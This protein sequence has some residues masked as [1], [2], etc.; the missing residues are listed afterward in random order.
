MPRTFGSTCKVVTHPLCDLVTYLELVLISDHYISDRACHEEA[1]GQAYAETFV[2]HGF[3]RCSVAGSSRDVLS[4][5]FRESE[6]RHHTMANRKLA[7][8]HQEKPC[9]ESRTPVVIVLGS[10]VVADSLYA[11]SDQPTV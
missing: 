3:S 9:S 2:R 1:E 11:E 10:L 8:V 5:K 7:W 4:T 6:Q